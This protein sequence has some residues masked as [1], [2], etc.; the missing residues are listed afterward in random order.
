MTTQA[1]HAAEACPN[2]HLQRAADDGGAAIT[3][4]CGAFY[5]PG[6]HT[7]YRCPNATRFQSAANEHQCVTMCRT[8]N[9]KFEPTE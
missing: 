5:R 3:C 8:C 9:R 6:G 1:D 4:S 7:P 2:D